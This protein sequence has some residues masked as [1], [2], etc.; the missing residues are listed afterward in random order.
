MRACL[1]LKHR[2]FF[3]FLEFYL[4]LLERIDDLLHF[5]ESAFKNIKKQW[6]EAIKTG[7]LRTPDEAQKLKQRI[8]RELQSYYEKHKATP[9]KTEM[10]KAIARNARKLIEEIIPEIKQLNQKEGA[11]IELWD[12]VP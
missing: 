12:A 3:G 6:K 10:R 4:H 8:Y 9:A 11:L 2:T 1:G 7:P 5:R